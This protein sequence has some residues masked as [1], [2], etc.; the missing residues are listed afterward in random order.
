MPKATV[1]TECQFVLSKNFRQG[2]IAKV[3]CE[4]NSKEVRFSLSLLKNLLLTRRNCPRCILRS[5][6]ACGVSHSGNQVK[7]QTTVSVGDGWHRQAPQ[8][9]PKMAGYWQWRKTT[10]RETFCTND[11][12]SRAVF[13]DCN[14]SVWGLLCRLMS[15]GWK[16][17]V[18]ELFVKNNKKGYSCKLWEWSLLSP[19]NGFRRLYYWRLSSF[20]P[21]DAYSQKCLL[22]CLASNVYLNISQL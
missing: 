3:T 11:P 13:W 7:W 10:D 19:S 6:E 14:L 20:C 9:P 5:S 21:A 1:T 12:F 22:S 17:Q 16:Q 15:C 2:F 4:L 8:A 18:W